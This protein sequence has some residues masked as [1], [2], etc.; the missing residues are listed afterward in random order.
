MTEVYT[1]WHGSLT[2]TGLGVWSIP[3]LPPPKPRCE[4]KQLAAPATAGAEPFEISVGTAVV[5]VVTAKQVFDI[6]WAIRSVAGREISEIQRGLRS[7]ERNDCEYARRWHLDKAGIDDEH[8]FK[9]EWSAW[10]NARY[11]I[12]ACKDGTIVIRG[13]GTCGKP[14]PT[15]RTDK[16]WK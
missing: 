2:E 6:G 8:R 10:P 15:I 16:R 4:L 12:C 14:G 9:D 3:N 5:V 1:A 13:H 7:G 11:D